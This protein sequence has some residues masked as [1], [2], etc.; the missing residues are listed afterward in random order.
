MQLSSIVSLADRFVP[1]HL[2]AGSEEFRRGRILVLLSF[3]GFVWGPV[4]AL[5]FVLVGASLEVA[6]ALLL[7]GF[8][9]A[10]IPLILRTSGSLSMSANVLFATLF[11]TVV[12][13]SVVRGG[14]PVSAL[15]WSISVPMLAVFLGQ[16][17]AA[18]VWLLAVAGKYAILG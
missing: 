8:T 4:F 15:M 2:K 5:V 6:T 16:R 7:S 13:V 14:Y 17:R 1:G 9:I 12:G 11:A 18:G 10:A 3:C